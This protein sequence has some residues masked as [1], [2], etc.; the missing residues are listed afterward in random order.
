MKKIILRLTLIF[1]ICASALWA[2]TK[3][4][5]NKEF[6]SYEDV[7]SSKQT[8]VLYFYSEGCFYCN[9][10][11]PAY[12]ELSKEFG[13]KFLFASVDVYDQK[14]S[15]LFEQLK[16]Y[17]V[18]MIFIYSP[19]TKHFQRISPYYYSEQSLRQIFTDYNS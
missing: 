4:A 10:L 7:V 19:Q 1:V 13:N 18:P 17:A 6:A 15:K 2:C 14:Y 11:M 3:F 8:S 9:R 5:K 12:K 16:I